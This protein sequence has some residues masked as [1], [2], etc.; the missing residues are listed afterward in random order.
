M[1]FGELEDWEMLTVPVFDEGER[2][3]EGGASGIIS[4]FD[5][6]NASAREEAAKV[7]GIV[8]QYFAR[9]PEGD[10]NALRGRLRSKIDIHHHAAMFELLLHELLLAA[11][12]IIEA[13]EPSVPTSTHKPDFLVRS[14]DGARFYLEAV[15]PPCISAAEAGAHRRLEEALDAIDKV[16]SADFYLSV[17]TT[18]LPDAPVPFGA[19]RQAIQAWVDS[20]D[21]EV[22]KAAWDAGS[23]I[24]SFEQ[25]HFGATFRVEPV[26]RLRSRGTLGE[27][28]IGA[29][30]GGV[31]VVE[32]HIS[33]HDAVVKKANRYGNLDLPLV[34]A[35]NAMGQFSG[36]DQ[37]DFALF[38]NEQIVI[39]GSVHR[40]QRSP[41]G[42]WYG[43]HG[44][45][46]QGVSAVLSTETLTAWSL[47]QRRARFFINPWANRVF[48]PAIEIDIC[49][50]ENERMAKEQGRALH[51]ILGLPADWPG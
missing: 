12:C 25:T 15:V 50:V 37:A 32:D 5:Y 47:G 11:G 17:F 16:N 26:P 46:K 18:G 7:R 30:M 24:A 39:N 13:V 33:I 2:T 34:V 23:P 21:Y 10:R 27:R 35:V 29:R 49:R 38:G 36:E 48:E 8:E 41:T 44:P 43:P 40:I 3:L 6:L 4:A 1:V 14:A 22:V 19:L 20:L 51:E 28:A 42:V 9:Y 45:R 31:Q